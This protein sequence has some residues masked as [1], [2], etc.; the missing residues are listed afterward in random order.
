MLETERLKIRRFEDS[1]VDGVHLMRSDPEVMRYIRET[2]KERSES[3]E[4]MRKISARW[5]T[6]GIGYCALVERSTGEFAGWC[7]LWQVPE[8][9]EIEVG[10][11]I[12]RSKWKMGYA[13]EAAEAVVGHGFSSLGLDHI[14]ALAYPENSASIN[15]MQKLGMTYVETGTFYGKRL[16]K[17]SVRSDEWR[18]GFAR[19]ENERNAASN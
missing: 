11:A 19:R 1:D 16:V 14:V 9:G 17:Y 5:D 18:N 7:G 13:T 8:T 10:Y 6:D 2:L 12:A 15:V 3:A 4:W